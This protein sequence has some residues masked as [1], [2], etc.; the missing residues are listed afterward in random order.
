ME[1]VSSRPLR[2]G[3]AGAAGK[4]LFQGKNTEREINSLLEINHS[5]WGLSSVQGFLHDLGMLLLCETS[6][7]C[8]VISSPSSPGAAATARFATA[9]G[10]SAFT[11]CLQSCAN[12]VS[13]ISKDKNCWGQVAGV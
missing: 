2:P 5:C 11:V 6:A 7:D 8:G 10:A 9:Q 12:A 4:E 3:H 1:T 13:Y